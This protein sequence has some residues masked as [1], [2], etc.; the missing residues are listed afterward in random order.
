MCVTHNHVK[1]LKRKLFIDQLSFSGFLTYVSVF[2]FSVPYSIIHYSVPRGIIKQWY[3]SCFC[4]PLY[5]LFSSL[6]QSRTFLSV[7]GSFVL[8]GVVKIVIQTTLA[9]KRETVRINML[10]Y[11]DFVNLFRPHKELCTRKGNEI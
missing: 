6:L 8:Y 11:T 3:C 4:S 7:N 5:Y 9:I 1:S 10:P 2:I